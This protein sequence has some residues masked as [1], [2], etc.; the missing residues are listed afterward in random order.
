M[1]AHRLRVVVASLGC[2]ATLLLGGRAHAERQHTVRE[3]QSL[4]S[5]ARGYQVSIST[6][7]AANQRAPDAPL[8]VGEVLSVPQKGVVV[9]A[10]GQSLSSVA[11]QHGCSV[12][13]LARQNKLS[14]TATLQPGMRLVLPGATK[15]PATP[16]A[17]AAS[18]QSMK[19]ASASIASATP[20]KAGLDGT[21][22][23]AAATTPARGDKPGRAPPGGVQLFRIATN[24][25]IRLTVTDAKGRV[26]PAAR[27]KLA[28]FLRPRNSTKQKPPESRLV[29][30]LAEISHHYEGRTIQVIS[31]YRK[32]GGYT[33][34]ESR[35]TKGA[36]ID[37]RV[38]GIDNRALVA[39]L[40]HFRDV[41]VGLYPNSNFVHLDVR[42]KNA[43]WVDLSSPGRRP[44][45]LDRE[46]R[47][48][49]D[50]KNKDEG[51]V[52]LGRSVE[53][54]LDQVAHGEPTGSEPAASDE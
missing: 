18:T 24:E 17:K 13:A 34:K 15:E 10:P 52:E 41:G 20:G 45:Y 37:M 38:D 28:R 26:R 29:A 19:A 42:D 12:D 33:S 25:R 6:L 47:D 21:S 43:Y 54:A 40:R 44:S 8:A 46:Q 49:F 23:R 50:G 53:Q 22:A 36:A 3:G 1:A 14:P 35:H 48:H 30:L 2:M 9:L 4:A 32:A 31:G 11:K 7:A 51:L 5:I 16:V 27:T 39:Y